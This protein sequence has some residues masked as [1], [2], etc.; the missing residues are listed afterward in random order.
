MIVNICWFLFG[1]LCGM[2]ALA[3]YV[4]STEAERIGRP[5]RKP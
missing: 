1:C 3:L 5:P 4:I 2:M